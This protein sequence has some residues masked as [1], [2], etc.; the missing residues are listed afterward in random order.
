MMHAAD[1]AMD[2]R[3]LLIVDDDDALRAQ[4]S[5]AMEKRG[6]TALPA[7]TVDEA[8]AIIAAGAP[9]FA[10]IDL[11][12]GDGN[13]LDVAS[14]ISD[15]RE[16]AR[17]VIFSG[18]GDIPTAVAAAKA[19]AAAD[20][21]KPGDADD[22]EKGVMAAR[23]V[24]PAPPDNA[25]SAEEIRLAHIRRVFNDT[26][27]NVSETARRLGMHRRTLQ[28]IL[29]KRSLADDPA[30]ENDDLDEAATDDAAPDNVSPTG[31][32]ANDDA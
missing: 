32:A 9:P 19:G 27:R 4:L 20:L 1:V 26:G 30:L 5:R 23:N 18:Y 13:G 24:Y 31:E 15:A 29:A 17:A 22:V 25:M 2:D 14:A 21:A 12:V 16:D 10:I 6:F 3:R 28:R 7:A 11:R 8:L